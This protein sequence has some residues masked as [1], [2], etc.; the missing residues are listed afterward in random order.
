MNDSVRPDF[1]PAAD[2][3]SKAFLQQENEKVWPHVWLIACREEELAKPGSYHVFDVVRETIL[4]VRQ[5]EGAIKA[6]YN[7]CQ[8]RGRKL[9]EGCGQIGKQIYCRFHG[10]SWN[11]DGSIRRVVHRAQWDGCPAFTDAEIAL[12]ELRVGTWG[13]WVFVCMDP[14]APELTDYL[15]QVPEYLDC[16]ALQDTRMVWSV[17]LRAP[18][19]WKLVLNAFNEAY[20]VEATHPQTRSSTILP[21]EARGIHSMFGPTQFDP[22]ELPNRPAA[23]AE[24][25]RDPR[26][27]IAATFEEMHRDLQAMYL[28]PGVAA[29]RR[30]LEELPP[31]TDMQVV[32]MKLLEFHR[33][34]LERRG[35]V[36]PEGLTPQAMRKAGF[37]WHLFPNFII[38]PSIDGSLCYR[39]RPDPEDPDHCIWDIWCFGRFA[40][41]EAPE[42]KHTQVEKYEDFFDVNRFL[43]DDLIN[44]PEVQKGM[45]SRG[46]R[47]LRTNPVQEACVANLH[48]V[49]HDYIAGRR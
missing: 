26:E 31:G 12:P 45:Y 28:E 25:Q 40:P 9:K 7:V 6:F 36:W 38:L 47:G 43:K 27:L 24:M 23:I 4:L 3:I 19:N 13:G 22:V 39:T 2:Y 16:Y 5:P 37:G 42:P 20:H 44:L 11:I 14:A 34:E 41:G 17:Q 46:F 48:K 21:S 15:G 33:E 35:V 32:G 30:L 8:H 18:A 10:W 1:V 29:A 49:I